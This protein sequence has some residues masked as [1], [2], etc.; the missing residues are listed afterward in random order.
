MHRILLV[1]IAPLLALSLIA[2]PPDAFA[3]ALKPN[4]IL[5]FT[6][7]VGLGNI[8]F[9]GGSFKTPNIDRLA[10]SG[11]QFKN[12]YA[13]PLCGPSR[14]QLLTG[15]YPFR[16]GHN[17]NQSRTADPSKEIMIPTVLKKAGYVSASCGKWGQIKLGPGDWGFDEYLIYPGSGRFWR[18]QTT[19]YT[20]NG[21]QIELP[22]NKHLPDIMHDFCADFIKRHRD[23]P[24]FLYYSMSHMH[25]PIVRT[26]ESKGGADK[27]QLYK[28]NNDYM[29]KLVGRLMEVLDREK[30]RENTLV[31][32]TCD[33][34]TARFG[35]ELAKV[36]G[37]SMSG[38]K[39]TMLEGGAHV[40][41]CVSWPGVAPAG[42][43]S[44][45]LVDST[46]FL[47][48]FAELAG[49]EL[50]EGL[51]FD[52]H[53]FAP[54]LMDQKGSPREWIYVELNGKSY[55]RD[56]RYKLT[57]GGEL[58][59]LKNAPFEEIPVGRN[60][61]D[62]A[63]AARKKLQAVLDDHKTLPPFKDGD[64]NKAKK[65]QKQRAR[66]KRAASAASAAPH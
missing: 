10:A 66:K 40:P 30:L 29:D 28:D 12:C 4:I 20:V 49:A 46:D 11:I 6:D 21:Q 8:G 24:F 5:I 9:S 61:S 36:N 13:T 2:A 43:V 3:A 41:T 42:M 44:D 59:D 37:K 38:Q 32:F 33:N 47:T 63:A 26:P 35:V 39:A 58:Y 57:N 19:H 64:K 65:K 34:G 22:E 18:E 27:D 23:N 53:S 51:K 31:V 54:Q 25:G 56:A 50:P 62:E 15:R 48:T 45:D 55:V 52:G 17:S 60:A 1:F 14:C 7:D 16:T